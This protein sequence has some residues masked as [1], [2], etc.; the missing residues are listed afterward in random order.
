MG[1]DLHNHAFLNILSFT[2]N[3]HMALSIN[4]REQFIQ[5]LTLIA[6][7][8]QEFL[9]IAKSFMIIIT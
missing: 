9:C 3:I 1:F 7:F 6:S 2:E 8:Y 4:L 5:S